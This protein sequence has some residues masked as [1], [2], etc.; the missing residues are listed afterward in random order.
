VKNW[1]LEYQNSSHAKEKLDAEKAVADCDAALK[2]LQDLKKQYDA[3]KE[4]GMKQL[5]ATKKKIKEVFC[6]YSASN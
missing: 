6:P 4:L 3:E 2:Q 5:E 1:R